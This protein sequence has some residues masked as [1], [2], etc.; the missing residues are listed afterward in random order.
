LA[1]EFFNKAK[2]VRL[3]SHLG[4]YLL[5]DDDEET[6]RQTRKGASSRQACWTVELVEGKSHVVR[7]KSCH[8]R[9]LT[10]S[11]EPFLL[12]MTGNKVL[13]RAT[14]CN[15]SSVEW[16]PIKEGCLV[17]LRA[18]GGKFL[19]ANGGTPPWRNS[20]THDIPHRTATQDWV[21]W[22]VDVVDIL[23]MPDRYESLSRNVSLAS[24]ISSLSDD[25][26][27][28]NS[29]SLS[30]ASDRSTLATSR[31]QEGMAFFHKAK[32]VRLQSHLG[33][34]L[35]ADDEEETV[36]QSRNGSSR[37]ARWSVEF[38]EGKS[39]VIR[40]KSCHGFY[41][42]ATSEAF[43]LGMTGKKVLQSLPAIK[44]D[45]TIEWEP[46]KEG[47]NMKL[48]TREGTFLRANGGM[49]PWRNSLTHDIPHRTATQDWV[50]WGVEVVNISLADAESVSSC[51]SMASSFSSMPNDFMG[52]PDTGSPLVVTPRSGHAFST[53]QEGMAF[54]HKAKAV[55]LQSH[56]GKYLVADD[57]EE[58]VR[59]SRN[60][61]SRKAHWS[62]EFIEGKSN[63]IRLKSCHG[64][65]LTATSE[66]FLLGMTGKKVL[67]SL[68]ARK[69]DPT[70]EWEPIKEGGNVKLHTKEGKFLR[71]NGGTPPWRNSV[72]HDIPH[73]TATQDWV[74]WGV[75]VVDIYL[76]DDE[77]L[78]SRLSMAS[79]F[80]SMPDD[81]R[82]SPDIGSPLA[83]TPR[84]GRA[85]SVRQV[86]FPSP[87]L[88]GGMEFFQ[89]AKSVRLRS[90]HE[91]YLL[92]DEDRETVYQDRYGS[93]KGA[94]WTVEF[95]ED[96]SN[97]VRL[98]SCFGK[99][100]TATDEQFLLGV[101]GRKVLQTLPKRLDSSI[102]WEPIRDGFQVRLKTRYGN[103]LRANGGV[104]PWRNSITHDIPHRHTD[105]ILWEVDLVENRPDSPVK[106]PPSD[107]ID[108]D[109]SSSSFHLRSPVVSKLES[110]NSFGGGSPMKSD[111][112]MIYFHVADDDGNFDDGME[113]ASFQLKGHGLE[114]LTAKLEEETGLENIIAC[115]KNPL[116]GKLY[117]LRLSLPPNNA[118]MNI[119]VLPP[120]S[121]GS[122]FAFSF[123][124]TLYLL[125]RYL[126]SDIF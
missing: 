94:M 13:Q 58:T 78:S 8:G 9:Y 106:V 4:K 17:K 11:D 32:A 25:F 113:G 35:V 42:T 119:V 93:N 63:V 24:S 88:S 34:Y 98:K 104:P 71:A 68:P 66:A 46:I 54:F 49:P 76:A 111:G 96:V 67:Q 1:M 107:P 97:V 51:L 14:N 102:E 40:L 23:T 65:Y 80:S 52:S 28:S 126:M 15:D 122:Y 47:E 75:E 7:L 39:N 87:H 92:A 114:E 120:T 77:S 26:A 89:K 22:E 62:V 48:Q 43:L 90:H 123:F 95:V 41:L 3:R 100:L 56:L 83:A 109:L 60:G 108:G 64:F 2:A 84:S 74:L 12:G 6:V 31:R 50:L 124:N 115:S 59:Q 45:P 72:T 103:Y 5:A 21:L 38:I 118:T 10:A 125:Y 79:S 101:T 53:R 73:R 121:K 20:I 36:R 55:R 37:K 19:R 16:E 44:M 99:Y 29:R 116:N 27:G 117:P 81:F 18:R 69:M 86:F 91:K 110:S 33:K 82:G 70:I 85:S 105:W 57:D 61:S 30:I 112:R